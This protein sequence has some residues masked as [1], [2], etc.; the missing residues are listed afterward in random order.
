MRYRVLSI[1]REFIHRDVK[2]EYLLEE[3]PKTLWL[4]LKARYDRQKELIWP[5]ANY[6]WNHLRLQDF[7]SIDEYNHAVHTIC[8]KLKF[9]EKEP[10][11][12]E[13]IEKTLS[14]MLPTDRVL[15]QQYRAS[16]FQVY[17]ELI[18]TLTQAEKHDELLLKNHHKHPTGAASLPEVNYNAQN[19][20]FNGKFQRHNKNFKA[21][22]NFNKQKS[23]NFAHGKYNSK[24]KIDKS[25]TCQ[26]CGCYK[27]TTKKCHTPRHLVDLYQQF[28]G[29]K[30]NAK[31]LRYEAHFNLQPDINKEASCSYQ[32][33]QEPTNNITAHPQENL[34][35]MENMIVEYASYDM[36]RDMD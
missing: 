32:V 5:E 35:S 24:P 11:N 23:N 4:A 29:R 22:P 25:K 2:V 9:C 10:I 3:N 19:N 33:P 6:E 28:L 36:F 15:Q 17:S 34:P 21:K 14:T 26:K 1:L 13:K 7:K 18:H 31:G 27:H 12:T 16:K 20:K 8:S 30:Q